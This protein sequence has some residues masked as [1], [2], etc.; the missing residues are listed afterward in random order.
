[1]ALIGWISGHFQTTADEG[2]MKKIKGFTLV[3]VM[4]VVLIIG[5]L[6]AI[7]VPGFAKSRK[8]TRHKTIVANLKAINDAKAQCALTEGLSSG[9]TGRCNKNN[10][11]N[12][13]YLK[14]WPTGPI[15]GTYGVKPIGESAVFRGK[16]DEWWDNNPNSN[17]L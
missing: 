14:T 4:I 11:I 3:E 6:L 2:T 15:S 5:T 8:T 9:D 7:A 13:G 12:R 10:L 16:D 17:L 1:M